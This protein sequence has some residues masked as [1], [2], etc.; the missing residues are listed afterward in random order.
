M[1]TVCQQHGRCASSFAQRT[2]HDTVSTNTAA[3]GAPAETAVDVKLTIPRPRRRNDSQQ[4]MDSCSDAAVACT[5]K[6]TNYAQ[7]AAAID[8][9]SVRIC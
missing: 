1:G 7:T 9:S 4:L 3:R 5:C 6:S 2:C 8:K